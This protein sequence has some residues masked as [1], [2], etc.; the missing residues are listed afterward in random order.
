MIFPYEYIGII[1]ILGVALL[2]SYYYYLSTDSKS[3]LLW[4]S[5]KGNLLNL[6]YVSMLLSAIGFLFLFTYLFVNKNFTK[7]NV[8]QLFGVIICILFFSI[9][10][11]PFSLMYLHHKTNINK[12]LTILILFLVAF[13]SFLLLIV[14][15]N[16]EEKKYILL[17]NLALIGM[18]YFFIHVFLFDFII[19]NVHFFK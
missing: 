10:W 11:M 13:F 15:K 12:Y 2:Y 18:S 3:T 9:F 17:K 7:T 14:L 16:I 5:V 19:W 6:Y 1:S 8:N 4:G